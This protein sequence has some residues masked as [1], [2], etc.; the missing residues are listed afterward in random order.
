MS[1][2]QGERK[3]EERAQRKGQGRVNKK[4][5]AQGYQ[6]Q[7]TRIKCL[8]KVSTPQPKIICEDPDDP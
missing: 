5:N 1:T 2:D 4:S 6:T 7:V 8:S 3:E